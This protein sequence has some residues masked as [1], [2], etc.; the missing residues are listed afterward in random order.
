MYCG[1]LFSYGSLLYMATQIASGMKH[2]ES[3]GVVHRDLA[4]RN[5]LVAPL[6]CV[7]I[8][9]LGSGRSSRYKM[10]YCSQGRYAGLPLRWMAWETIILV[11]VV[12]YVVMTSFGFNR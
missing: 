9:D 10:D 8:S 4:A 12:L 3:L 5:C 11:S 2:L 7:K 1:M 6:Y